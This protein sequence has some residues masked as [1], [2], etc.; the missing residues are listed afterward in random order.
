MSVQSIIKQ[1]SDLLQKIKDPGGTLETELRA[2]ELQHHLAVSSTILFI[3]LG[4]IS[5]EEGD[6]KL[7]QIAISE[8]IYDGIKSVYKKIET[9]AIEAGIIKYETKI[10]DAKVDQSTL[11][12]ENCSFCHTKMNIVLERG[13]LECSNCGMLKA[14]SYDTCQQPKVATFDPLRH[15]TI[16][17]KRICG[18]MGID[19][20]CSDDDPKG[21]K[22]IEQLTVIARHEK[23]M[24]KKVS[25]ANI[26]KWLHMIGRTD[27]YKNASLIKIKMTGI[28]PPEMGE[29]I[30][31]T[32]HNMMKLVISACN[33]KA[34][35][36]RNRCYYPFYGMKILDYILPEGDPKRRIFEYF[37]VQG[38]Q[39]IRKDDL[40]WKEICD[41]IHVITYRPTDLSKIIQY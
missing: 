37:H 18:K 21:E 31:S 6:R 12:Y 15:F 17:W 28:K 4:K 23:C 19:E 33:S 39:T 13:Q 20:L 26:R 14:Q 1:S 34:T 41:K 8:G 3:S 7:Q 22:V 2:I 25:I 36:R 38:E 10:S 27:L 35:D 16:G 11:D 9:K 40:D 29:E 5:K 32:L 24:I 30:E